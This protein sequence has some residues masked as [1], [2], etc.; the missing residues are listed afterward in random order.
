MK[1]YFSIALA[2]ACTVLV[3][4]LF[5]M[6]RGDN[7]QHESDAGAIADFSNRLD[8]AQTQVAICKGTM[9]VVSN[10]LV[11]SQSASLTFSNQWIEAESTMAL[12]AEQITNLNRQVAEL[13]SENQTLGQRVM[14]LTNQ[15]T[16]RM[17]GLTNQIALT[18]ASLDQANKDYAL[19]EN[20]FRIDV[21][22]RVVVERKFNNP[23]ELKA[24][25][26]NLEWSPSHVVSAESIYAGLDVE[27]KSNK[28]HV[29][30]PN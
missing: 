3:I 14:D 25:I 27:V 22:E 30:S 19:L 16:S 11:E 23:A 8:S 20:R 9:T 29:I 2:L 13:T 10:N 15:M 24:Q 4:S 12:D 1:H 17:A 18:Q 5:V 26:E 28:L 7:A 21:A 6:K